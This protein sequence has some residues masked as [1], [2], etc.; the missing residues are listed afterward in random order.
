[1]AKTKIWEIRAEAPD[2]DDFRIIQ[3]AG[4]DE[5]EARLNAAA[6][7]VADKPYDVVSVEEIK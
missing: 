7:V 5:N 4:E 1:M 2:S 6:A 3:V